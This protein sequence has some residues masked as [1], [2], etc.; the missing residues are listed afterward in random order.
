MDDRLPHAVAEVAPSDAISGPVR[1]VSRDDRRK[2]GLCVA[3]VL[4]EKDRPQ[5]QRNAVRSGC[6]GDGCF[7]VD[8]RVLS[9]SKVALNRQRHPAHVP[10]LDLLTPLEGGHDRE[11]HG[12]HEQRIPPAVSDLLAVCVDE[13]RFEDEDWTP[14]CRNHPSTPVPE[15]EAG[16]HHQARREEHAQRDGDAV[17]RLKCTRAA[18]TNDGQYDHQA[19]NPV[20]HRDIDLATLVRVGVIH[21]HARKQTKLDCLRRQREHTGDQSL[22]RDDR[23]D[24]REDDE[25]RERFSLEMNSGE[26]RVELR[27]WVHEND[28]ALSHVLKHQ[29]WGD[30][31]HPCDPDSLGAEVA[32]VG[33]EC[34]ATGCHQEH[35][36]HDRASEERVCDQEL[37]RVHRAQG[38][39]HLRL[40]DQNVIEPFTPKEEEPEQHDRPEDLAD[41]AGALRLNTEQPDQ[42]QAGQRNHHE[43]EDWVGCSKALNSGEDADCGSQNTVAVDQ[44]RAEDASERCSGHREHVAAPFQGAGHENHQRHDAALAAIVSAEDKRHV[45]QGHNDEQRPVDQGDDA[46]DVVQDD[47]NSMSAHNSGRVPEPAKC[48]SQSVERARA[49]IAVDDAECAQRIPECAKAEPPRFRVMAVTVF[50]L[51]RCSIFRPEDIGHQPVPGRNDERPRPLLEDDCGHLQRRKNGEEE[52]LAGTWKL[53]EPPKPRFESVHLY[54]PNEGHVALADAIKD[55]MVKRHPPLTTIA[56]AQIFGPCVLRPLALIVVK[57][58][59]AL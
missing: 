23:R 42:D 15:V 32:H 17:G 8:E 58:S 57:A 28:R 6:Q 55:D 45:L 9:C 52:D 14:D 54:F 4:G 5:R 38:I 39:Q 27:F 7:W 10:A 31:E 16:E 22:R 50:C 25:H 41:F 12:A 24:R 35:T 34:F 20:D 36:A 1:F 21:R 3:D 43:A 47:R 26:E 53:C 33:V 11:E 59:C 37:D 13:E 44:G 40:V 19:D 18:E 2:N 30:D 51:L 48:G 56:Y 49:D 29:T 46:K